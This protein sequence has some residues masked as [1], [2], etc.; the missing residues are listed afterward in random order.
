MIISVPLRPIATSVPLIQIVKMQT[1]GTLDF[2]IDF[3][4]K[5]H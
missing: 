4:D 1:N 2:V 5:A 3:H